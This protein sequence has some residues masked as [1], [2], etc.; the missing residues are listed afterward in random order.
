MAN[1][2]HT[3]YAVAPALTLDQV[4]ARIL[5]WKRVDEYEIIRD[6]AKI[7]RLWPNAAQVQKARWA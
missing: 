5:H 6:A 1:G 3:G 4:N 2:A 7:K